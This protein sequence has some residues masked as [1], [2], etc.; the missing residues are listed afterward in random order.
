M[1]Q[2]QRHVV[3]AEHCSDLP[4]LGFVV[5]TVMSLFLW[6]FVGSTIWWLILP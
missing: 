5:G 1:T 3:F 6:L 2:L 4:W